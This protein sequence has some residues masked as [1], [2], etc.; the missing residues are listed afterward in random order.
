M[1]HEDC[2]CYYNQCH[3]EEDDEEIMKT[4]SHEVRNP[5]LEHET[6]SIDLLKNLTEAIS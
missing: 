1:K 6:T 3:N 2:I 4:Y 5:L